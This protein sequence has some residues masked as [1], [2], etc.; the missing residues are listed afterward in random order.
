MKHIDTSK[1]CPHRVRTAD[2]PCAFYIKSDIPGD[3]G[4]CSRPD[5]FHCI[6]AMRGGL[7]PII[8]HSAVTDH[9]K[10][11][12]ITY[13]TKVLGIRVHDHALPPVVLM[14]KGVDMFLDL[15]AKQDIDAYYKVCNAMDSWGLYETH[16]AK[17]KATMRAIVDLGI[18]IEPTTQ[19]QPE[20]CT[21]LSNCKLYGHLDR[22]YPNYM[23]ES[24]FTSRPETYLSKFYIW[25]QVGTYFLLATEAEY[26]IMEVIQS[27][28]QRY[29]DNKETIEEYEQRI[30]ADITM[31]P[32]HYFKNYKAISKK[33][34]WRFLRSEFNLPDIKQQ[35]ENRAQKMLNDISDGLYYEWPARIYC[36][37]PTPCWYKKICE[38]GVVSEELYYYADKKSKR[39]E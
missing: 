2:K 15:Y 24:K 14:G 13:Y 11:P 10:C 28:Q 27:P 30:Y 21:D 9:M 38:T 16:Q 32:G 26:C 23:V 8:S 18:I 35:Y 29:N 34:G 3:C 12:M 36:D 19:T 20:L 22:L 1:P 5:M 4:F 6:E 39:E 37:L 7:L 31:R 33:F 25:H 17:V